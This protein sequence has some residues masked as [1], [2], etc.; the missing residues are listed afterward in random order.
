M[1]QT[2]AAPEALMQ[3]SGK[4]VHFKMVAQAPPLLVMPCQTP[5][6]ES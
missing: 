1:T 4:P 3:E 6:T 2:K 5:L